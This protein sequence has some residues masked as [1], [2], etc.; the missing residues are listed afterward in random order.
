MFQNAE[1]FNQDIGS[2][3][4]SN[5]TYIHSMFQ[6]AWDFNQDIGNWDVSNVYNMAQMFSASNLST[7]N[8]DA[9]LIGWS[10]LNLQPT[11]ELGAVG[12]T[13]CNGEQARQSIIDNFGWD[14][15]DAGLAT[16]C[17]LGIDDIDSSSVFI[18]PNPIENV[19]FVESRNSI[20][21]IK[22]YD[23]L[24][25]LVLEQSNPSNQIDTSSLSSGLLLLQIETEDG[26]V[27]K[28]VLKE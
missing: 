10:A 25:R 26:V 7:E 18:Y 17:I 1:D 14:I 19:L 16:D 20:N 4:V 5:V 13:Y 9:I 11:V 23:I 21:Y 2:W 6:R 3:D 24:G 8:Y 22:V 12:I 27:T 28:K 15:I